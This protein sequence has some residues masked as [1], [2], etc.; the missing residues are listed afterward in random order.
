MNA[1][2]PCS[3]RRGS[4]SERLGVLAGFREDGH[5]PFCGHSG[6]AVGAGHI[7]GISKNSCAASVQV[8]MKDYL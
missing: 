4:G 1:L 3:E 7:N 2:V 8:L 5:G 6:H